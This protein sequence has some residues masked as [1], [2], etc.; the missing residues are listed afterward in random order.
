M[1]SI[2]NRSTLFL[3]VARLLCGQDQ[4][5]RHAIELQRSGDLEGAARE[6]RTFLSTHPN[7]AGIRSNLGVVLAQLARYDEAEK[8]YEEALRLQ[9][10]NHGIELNLALAYYKGGRIPDAV[11]HLEALHAQQPD[12]PQATLLLADSYLRMGENKKVIGLLDAV[13]KNDVDNL[14][15]AYL[16]GTA[17]IRESRIA[18]G[19]VVIDRILKDAESPE[20]HFLLGSQMFAAGDFPSAVQQFKIAAA[21]NPDLPSLQSYYGQALL[22]TGDPDGA[23]DAFRKELAHDPNDFDSNLY[24]AEILI[25]RHKTEE[26]A[27]L[28]ER[29]RRVRPGSAQVAAVIPRSKGAPV[30]ESRFLSAPAP[31]FTLPRAGAG[32]P[33]SLQSFRDKSPVLLVFGSYSCPNFRSAAPSLINLY[34]RYGTKIPFLMVYIREAHSTADWQS[35]RNEREGIVVP[36]A[37]TME[38]KTGHASMC[39]RK[40]NLP[41]PAVVDGMD[42]KVES[43][44][45][46]WPSHAYL[47]D[48]GGVIRYATGL[49]E[50]DFHPADLEAAIRGV[51]K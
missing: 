45:S 34:R 29:A 51:A 12:N 48:A 23:A 11:K 47:I 21:R 17:L 10:Q 5:V 35:T 4:T 50:L 36:E 16:L 30:S 18:E 26:A 38:D 40:L 8:E 22:N 1:R 33:I 44:Y 32:K 25:E 41:F 37:K 2:R 6:Y 39:L 31:D 27:P 14:G 20:A 46:A 49:T 42:G 3:L 7:E 24:L 15:V 19:Q 13:H 43:A 9:P 28:L